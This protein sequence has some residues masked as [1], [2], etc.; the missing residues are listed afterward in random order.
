MERRYLFFSCSFFVSARIAIVPTYCSFISHK[1][2]LSHTH[3]HTFLTLTCF[4]L[5]LSL[6][7]SFSLFN[8]CLTLLSQLLSSNYKALHQNHFHSFY[9]DI[10]IFL[11]P[12]QVRRYRPQYMLTISSVDSLEAKLNQAQDD[13]G[14]PHY[15]RIPVT[16]RSKAD[17]GYVC[18]HVSILS[19]FDIPYSL[20][21]TLRLLFISPRDMVRLLFESGDYLRAMFIINL[22]RN[23]HAWYC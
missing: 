9:H 8:H 15:N 21:Q 14:I 1:L 17:S 13:L 6:S 5:S 16:Y 22:K 11:L 19:L 23:C 12:M 3:T 20:D 7:L 10:L 2:S 18:T 4:S